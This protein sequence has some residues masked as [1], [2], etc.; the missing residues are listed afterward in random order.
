MQTTKQLESHP[1]NGEFIKW[2]IKRM[3][4]KEIEITNNNI[5]DY[6]DVMEID[7]S[8]EVYFITDS[9]GFVSFYYK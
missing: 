9:Y 5:K 2:I 8:K 3:I 6:L 7:I 4:Y 1:E